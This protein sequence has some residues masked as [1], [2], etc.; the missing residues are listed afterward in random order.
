M[1]NDHDTQGPCR[2]R[3]CRHARRPRRRGD[4]LQR[5]FPFL[6]DA[7]VGTFDSFET[8]SFDGTTIG[9]SGGTIGCSD[10]PWCPLFYGLS[11][12]LPDQ[13]QSGVNAPFFATPSVLTFTFA[14]PILAFGIFI[15]GAGDVG[16]QTLTAV[17]DGVT[18]LPVLTDYVGVGDGFPG[19][20]NFWG[21]ISAT[22]FTTVAF[23]GTDDNDG[24]FLDDLYYAIA[25]A[26]P[27]IVPL[28]AA[29]LLLIGALGGLALFRRRRIV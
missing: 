2:R 20:T 19:N 23:R 28:P 14:A 26:N 17:I 24:V 25:P 15:G 5:L 6:A 21:V 11:F 16:I 7:E 4:R 22:P 13:A 8:A 29:G 12:G 1:E 9:F 10:G 18:T 3:P 27:P